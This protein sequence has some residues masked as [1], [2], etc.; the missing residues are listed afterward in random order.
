M[1]RAGPFR[2]MRGSD[3]RESGRRQKRTLPGDDWHLHMPGEQ[4]VQTTSVTSAG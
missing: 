2:S 4:K 1:Y 3:N